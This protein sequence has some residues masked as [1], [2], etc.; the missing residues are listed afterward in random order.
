VGT[1]LRETWHSSVHEEPAIGLSESG[2]KGELQ[3][4]LWLERLRL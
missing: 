2:A 3:Q 1:F 4:G